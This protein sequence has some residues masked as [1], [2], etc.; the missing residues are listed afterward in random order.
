MRLLYCY[1]E[2]LDW[3]GQVMAYR[4]IERFEW[5]LARDARYHYDALQNRLR[6][7]ASERPLPEDF[8]GESLYNINV[9]AG[10]NGAG[11]STLLCWLRDKL[12]QLYRRDFESSD[13]CV[14]LFEDGPSR[15]A[16]KLPGRS[17][18][19]A[20]L[21]CAFSPC[22][23]LRFPG[24]SAEGAAFLERLG[25]VKL[26]YLNNTL[27]E[28]DYR[29]P[30][31]NAS[32]RHAFLYDR[33]L[34]GALARAESRDS[35]RP[36]QRF[37]SGEQY[38]QVK[39]LFDR[40][41]VELLS[42]LRESIADFPAPRTL[43]LRFIADDAILPGSR[44]LARDCGRSVQKKRGRDDYLWYVCCLF[45][46]SFYA[47][48][49]PPRS[50]ENLYR[51]SP[52]DE[53]CRAIG[54]LTDR[55]G[56]YDLLSSWMRQ[57][58]DAVSETAPGGPPAREEVLRRFE[59]LFRFVERERDGLFAHFELQNFGYSVSID[60]I[61]GDP[62]LH[63]DMMAFLR[64]YRHSCLPCYAL[65][66]SWG[67]SSGEDNLLRLFSS[68][69]HA[70]DRGGEQDPIR[71]YNR[72]DRDGALVPCDSVW[73]FLDEADLSFHPEWQRRLIKLLSAFLPRVYPPDCARDIQLLLSTHSP[74]LLGD[75]PPENVRYLPPAQGSE[76]QV[77]SF[78]QNI[79]L[80]LKNSFFLS[81]TL[82]EFA[83]GK[84]NETARQL[85]S[86]AEERSGEREDAQKQ[87][88]ACRR[89]VRL[90]APGPIR[91]RLEQLVR[92]AEAALGVGD[93][94]WELLAE[95]AGKLP[96]EAR[97]A[98]IERLKRQEEEG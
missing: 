53:A 87:L 5:N 8:W 17:G 60:E 52:E 96:P 12:D 22:T 81:S 21:Q 67:V 82:G 83:I 45:A 77:E 85:L 95:E 9:L 2:F 46:L 39:Y 24:E 10:K 58:C 54:D 14:L 79:H 38:K 6:R 89:T 32:G 20:P 49:A 16:V 42:E 86:L 57:R 13:L 43:Y 7:E 59:A 65:D 4:G 71:L 35:S 31:G 75:I 68:F 18:D 73:V 88:E 47:N 34:G 64:L 26:I 15:F 3:E 55:P 1:V 84:I 36:M 80:L 33:S 50:D 29:R 98:L 62:R 56:R 40:R 23:A 66:L 70:F 63:A 19:R 25:R 48:I 41:Q 44:R 97:A 76:E 72:P 94:A 78:G 30:R 91:A 69:Y 90:V 51:L 92:A 37:F 61:S 27:N 74:L 28:K 93:A 11:K